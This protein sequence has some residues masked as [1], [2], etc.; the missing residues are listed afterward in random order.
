M[1]PPDV[2]SPWSLQICLRLDT[3]YWSDLDIWIGTSHYDFSLTHIF[4]SPIK[5]VADMLLLLH[6]GLAQVNM[7]L[8][9][10][11]GQHEWQLT[12]N[13]LD[14]DLI[15]ITISTY[16]E[17]F[18]TQNPP[19]EIRRLSVPRELF[20]DSFLVELD[21]IATLL[22]YPRFAQDRNPEAFPWEEW[23]QLRKARTKAE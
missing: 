10:E 8:Y 14:P 6:S 4:G 12:R 11:P 21:K 19:D 1:K 5:A 9:E 3:H 23:R 13:S 15:D 7:T 17:Y 16:G 22:Q 18:E 2:L 20:L